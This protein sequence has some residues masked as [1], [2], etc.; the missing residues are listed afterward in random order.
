MKLNKMILLALMAIVS[1][2]SSEDEGIVYDGA[3]EIK[4]IT[5]TVNEKK[6]IT[7]T[8]SELKDV[9]GRDSFAKDD[10]IVFTTIKRTNSELLPFIYSNI[11]Y[12]YDG[13]SWNRTGNGT[14]T[15]PEKIY[16]TDGFSAH[17]FIGYSL[18]LSNYKFDNGDGTYSGQLGTTDFKAG[19]SDIMAE[20]LLLCYSLNTKAETG[21]LTTKVNF[22]HALS[23]VRVVVNISG[24]A[25]S[26]SAVDTNVVVNNMVIKDQPTKYTWNANGS[27]LM[28]DSD[29]SIQDITL[30]CPKDGY[31]SSGQSKTFTFYGLTVPHSGSVPFSFE[32]SYPDPLSAGSV[33]KKNYQGVFSNVILESGKCT[34][35]A[36]SLN[37]KDEQMYMDV[38]YSDWNYVATPDIGELRKKSTFMTMTMDDVMIHSAGV[39]ADDATWL[40]QVGSEVYDVYGNDGSTD[41]PYRITSAKQMLSF[42]KEVNNGYDFTG[43]TIRLDA[44][45]T[46]QK[47]ATGDSYSWDGI[48][49]GEVAFNGTFLG[50]DRYINRLKGK[51]LFINLGNSA[52][53]EQLYITTVGEVAD[54]ALAGTNAGV[55]GACKVVDEVNTT[56]G[57]LVGTNTGIVY[58]SYH[59]NAVGDIDIVKSNSD[60]GKTVG[61]YVASDYSAITSDKVA[62]MNTDLGVL[63]GQNAKLTQFEYVYSVGNYPT[64]SKKTNP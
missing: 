22:T 14:A 51:P 30:W 16:W 4:G 9:I 60:D 8:I 10:K 21:G 3:L 34:T 6:Q 38:S 59:T 35:L 46:M 53:V 45:I 52:C 42:A 56:G 17:T 5:A 55:I 63:Y 29:P 15:D 47:T 18:P 11:H 19:N 2:C 64:V 50:G 20:D 54:G 27:S 13:R 43:K 1:A 49:I 39:A 37:H 36:I 31:E 61:C 44:D 24:Y 26:S 62:E 12:Q 40:Y 32:V 33:L 41:N 58:A 23:N 57:A 25:A 48:G 28:V 7:R